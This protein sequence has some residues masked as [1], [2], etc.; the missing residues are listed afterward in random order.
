MSANII[1]DII[2]SIRDRVQSSYCIFDYCFYVGKAIATILN[3]IVG[4]N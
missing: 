2:N 1:V 4:I 3:N